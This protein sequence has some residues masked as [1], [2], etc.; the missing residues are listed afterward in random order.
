MPIRLGQFPVYITNP[1][2]MPLDELPESK[3]NFLLDI[4]KALKNEPSVFP[5]HR[6]RLPLNI[7]GQDLS[8]L[9]KRAHAAIQK[10]LKDRELKKYERLS[11]FQN[12]FYKDIT[13]GNTES[14]WK[15]I[16]SYTRSY[17]TQSFYDNPKSFYENITSDPKQ[18]VGNIEI[19]DA[20]GY[21]E[22]Y[23]MSLIA[24]LLYFK[25]L[26]GKYSQQSES[27][28]EKDKLCEALDLGTSDKKEYNR[29]WRPG[30]LKKADASVIAKIMAPGLRR[31]AAEAV[32]D[33]MGGEKEYKA[34]GYYFRKD[35]YRHTLNKAQITNCQ[36]RA[37]KRKVTNLEAV[38]NAGY[39]AADILKLYRFHLLATQQL[40][41][42]HR[43]INQYIK[44]IENDD[45]LSGDYIDIYIGKM[46][47]EMTEN[48][49]KDE[50]LKK[51]YQFYFD[52]KSEGFVNHRNW[53]TP[54]NLEALHAQIEK[55][56]DLKI[57]LQFLTEGRPVEVED[58]KVIKNKGIILNNVKGIKHHWKSS[59]PCKYLHNCKDG[60]W[61]A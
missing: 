6:Y 25:K 24:Y 45:T 43:E 13:D 27:E 17:K 21:K 33:G 35:M 51:S 53:A 18:A 28:S 55:R 1:F 20:S 31:I 38:N 37:L 36:Q 12:R 5:W 4:A 2:L 11:D 47:K 32:I 54:Y 61:L 15:K 16:K 8:K 44:K 49:L 29:V 7:A 56:L 3:K 22:A 42:K 52:R 50:T 10:F 60:R 58:N 9:P 19:D 59:I 14:C 41:N 46:V 30:K 34:I 23:A 57:S 48:L 26:S 40:K 39:Y